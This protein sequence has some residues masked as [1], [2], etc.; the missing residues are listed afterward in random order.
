[1]L[2]DLILKPIFAIIQWMGGAAEG[3]RID[4]KKENQS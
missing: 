1:M 4:N 2:F 3:R